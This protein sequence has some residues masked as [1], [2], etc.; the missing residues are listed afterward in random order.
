MDGVTDSLVMSLIKL[1]EI[2]KHREAYQAAV[3]GV[4]KGW[5]QLSD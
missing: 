3:Y 1:Q 5:T 2:V 4:A